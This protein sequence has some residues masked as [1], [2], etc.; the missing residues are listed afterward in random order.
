MEWVLVDLHKLEEVVPS[1]SA[2]WVGVQGAPMAA[3]KWVGL[4]LS[5][6]VGPAQAGNNNQVWPLTQFCLVCFWGCV[7]ITFALRGRGG[8]GLV[9][10]L[11]L[12]KE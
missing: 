3:H 11:H 2:A 9:Y 10:L 6:L 5:K 4:A 7:H 12:I 1:K 8:G